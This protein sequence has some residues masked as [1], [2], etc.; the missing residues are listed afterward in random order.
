MCTACLYTYMKKKK[1]GVREY[2]VFIKKVHFWEKC[3]FE[4]DLFILNKKRSH[5]NQWKFGN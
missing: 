2:M 1:L 5:P 4:W 3:N